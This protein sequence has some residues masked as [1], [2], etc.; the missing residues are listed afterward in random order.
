MTTTMARIKV[1]VSQIKKGDRFYNEYWGKDVIAT[2]DAYR[3]DGAV[4][5]LYS[6][7]GPKPKE[8][9]MHYDP[10]SG[11]WLHSWWMIQCGVTTVG[12][13][14]AGGGWSKPEYEYIEVMR[15]EEMA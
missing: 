2:T 15:E 10:T 13:R 11:K 6:D 9:V 1:R 3:L 14:V 5:P 4:D 8:A 7:R 12:D